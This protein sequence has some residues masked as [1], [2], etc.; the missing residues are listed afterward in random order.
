MKAG[1]AVKPIKG[2]YILRPRA[3]IASSDSKE[4]D[5]AWSEYTC[6]EGDLK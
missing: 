6:E 2:L 5:R 3:K 1:T 4:H